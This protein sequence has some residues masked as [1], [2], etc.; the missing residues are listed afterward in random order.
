MC[1][2]VVFIVYAKSYIYQLFCN[3]CHTGAPGTSKPPGEVATSLVELIKAKLQ[4]VTK[5]H[6]VS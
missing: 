2:Y 5:P 3:I 1:V 6:K 4:T